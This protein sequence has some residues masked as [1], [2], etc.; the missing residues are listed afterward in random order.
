MANSFD[1]SRFVFFTLT[2]HF[3]S[4]IDHS[5]IVVQ[6]VPANWLLAALLSLLNENFV[7]AGP[8]VAY[9][10]VELDVLMF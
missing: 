1:K 5:V 9:F 3:G 6:A 4:I 8:Y 2:K 7:E 10:A